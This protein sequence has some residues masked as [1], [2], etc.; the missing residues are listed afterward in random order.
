MDNALAGTLQMFQGRAVPG[1]A[2]IEAPKR[3]QLQ[4]FKLFTISKANL[5]LRSPEPTG[6][7]PFSRKLPWPE[8]EVLRLAFGIRLF[9]D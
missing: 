8:P 2:L 1:E 7:A 4:I 5:H 3:Q 6:V 9:W